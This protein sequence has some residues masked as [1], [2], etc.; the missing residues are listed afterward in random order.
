MTKQTSLFDL[1][2]AR[3]ARDT[4]MAQVSRTPT[5]ATWKEDFI[6]RIRSL[7]IGYAG[8]A[9]EL[10]LKLEMPLPPGS[11]NLIGATINAAV[12]ERLLTWTGRMR[13]PTNKKSHAR[14]TQ[15]W[16]RT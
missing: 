10:R 12:R 6:E 13:S 7:P 15:E 1:I 11:P 3:A 16:R 8:T 9:E 2:E 14:R 4:G 5:A